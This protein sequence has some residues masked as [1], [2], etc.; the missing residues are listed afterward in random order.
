MMELSP[1]AR[2]ALPSSYL[3]KCKGT[4][5]RRTTSSWT[6]NCRPG[7]T[8]GHW[9]NPGPGCLNW[10][11]ANNQWNV[12]VSRI[13]S[14]NLLKLMKRRRRKRLDLEHV[15]CSQRFFS[16]SE[17]QG[18]HS[19]RGILFHCR[20]VKTQPFNSWHSL[21]CEPDITFTWKAETT[22]AEVKAHPF[23]LASFDTLSLNQSL[24]SSS[25]ALTA[26][27]I[28]RFWSCPR[29]IRLAHTGSGI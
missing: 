11:V 14:Q 6:R 9:R 5:S 22:P 2:P 21:I 17:S 29:N 3:P 18:S 10:V 4:S 12:Q 28:W 13:T 19:V 23:F 16:A 26:F 27:H 8:V 25:C 20:F 1:A 15:L 7:P 24:A